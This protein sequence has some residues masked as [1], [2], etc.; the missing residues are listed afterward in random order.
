MPVRF[1]VTGFSTF[2]EVHENPTERLVQRLSQ[3]LN[4]EIQAE[5]KDYCFLKAT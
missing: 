3:N 1:L 5:G 2:G 4:D